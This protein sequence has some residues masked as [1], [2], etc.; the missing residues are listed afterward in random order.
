[1]KISADGNFM[2]FVDKNFGNLHHWKLSEPHNKIK[3]L[4]ENDSFKSKKGRHTNALSN[5]SISALKISKNQ[6]LL[7]VSF[8]NGELYLFS[9]LD[10]K[11]VRSFGRVSKG[12]A[13]KEESKDGQTM[14]IADHKSIKVIS[15]DEKIES[16]TYD[17][18]SDSSISCI[19]LSRDGGYLWIA[20]NI[21]GL[22]RMNVENGI[23][24]V[25]LKATGNV[26]VRKMLL[27]KKEDSL[28]AMDWC[29]VIT[30][31]KIVGDGNLI[32]KN[33]LARKD[34]AKI[35]FLLLID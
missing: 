9:I 17:K 1:M 27:G 24:D 3:K 31:Y 22:V 23:V 5:S 8:L 33:E 18:V 6:S 10:K 21:G 4:T 19:A 2:I 11:V 13:D 29:D 28:Y 32:N 26:Q 15:I 30:K 35:K 25:R 7:W 14:Y 34:D 16:Q 20:N 12:Y